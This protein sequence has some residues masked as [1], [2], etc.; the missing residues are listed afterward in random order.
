MI[1]AVMRDEAFTSQ[2]KL[3]LQRFNSTAEHALSN[4]HNDYQ[5]LEILLKKVKGGPFVEDSLSSKFNTQSIY[6]AC[7]ESL[8]ISPEERLTLEKDKLVVTAIWIC[9]LESFQQFITVEEMKYTTLDS[10][11]RAYEDHEY[12]SLPEAE[13]INLWH[14]ANWMNVLFCMIPARRTKD[15]SIQIVSKFIQ[16]WEGT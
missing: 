14:T 11:L 1:D 7:F 16:G 5:K 10:F 6:Y 2:S 9:L 13:Q 8:G 4:L 3:F 12:N 15:L